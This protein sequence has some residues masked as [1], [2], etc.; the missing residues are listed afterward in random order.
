[1]VRDLIRRL[2]KRGQAWLR[3]ERRLERITRRVR[4]QGTGTRYSHELIVPLNSTYAPWHDDKQ[5]RE[6][7]DAI[8]SH[9]LVDQY[10]CYELWELLGQ[11]GHLTGDVLEVGVWRG[12]TGI[13]LAKRAKDLALGA[14]VFLADTF[15]GVTKAGADDPWYRGGEHADTSVDT[16]R[17]LAKSHDVSVSILTGMFPEDTGADIADRRFRMAHIDVDVHDSSRDALLWVWPRLEVGGIVVFDDYGSFECEGVT[18]L[19]RN[20]FNQHLNAA[21][22]VHNLNGHLV[23]FKLAD[24]PW[25]ASS[26][27]TGGDQIS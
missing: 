19:G 4:L 16:V 20:L 21:R 8:G 15:S 12:G 25:P 7:Y 18:S 1:M 13:L 26:P 5:F 22:L 17:A 11:L 2:A 24:E 27:L 3:N 23:L 9:T 10:R 14:E 6:L